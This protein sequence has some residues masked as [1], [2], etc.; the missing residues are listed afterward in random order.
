ME[1]VYEKNTK[2]ANVT[3]HRNK[4]GNNYFVVYYKN[5]ACIRLTPKEVGRVFGIAK[6]TPFVND[7]REWCYQMV[8]KYDSDGT[9]SECIDK[10]G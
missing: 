3:Y 2:E 1:Y 10:D 5:M 8:D 7:L 4:I 9:S 6:F